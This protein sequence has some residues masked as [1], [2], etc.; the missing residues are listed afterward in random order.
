MTKMSKLSMEEI[1]E[2]IE[3][4]TKKKG[5]NVDKF[6]SEAIEWSRSKLKL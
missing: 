6:V 4:T 3:S 2:K 1:S 5:I